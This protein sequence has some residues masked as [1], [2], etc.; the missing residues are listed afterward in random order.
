MQ[1]DLN[2]PESNH[3]AMRVLRMADTKCAR[4]QWP[5][6]TC[7]VDAMDLVTI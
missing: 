2:N 3:Y 6:Q 5:G 1:I 7:W 4:V